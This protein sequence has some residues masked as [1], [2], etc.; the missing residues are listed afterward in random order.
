M[1]PDPFPH[2]PDHHYR[3]PKDPLVLCTKAKSQRHRRLFRWS[4]PDPTQMDVYR[5]H[6]R[7]V[8]HRGAVWRLPGH[9]CRFRER[10]SRRGTIYRHGCGS[11]WC[12]EEECRAASLSAVELQAED[13]GWGND[14]HAHYEQSYQQRVQLRGHFREQAL[15]GRHRQP[16]DQPHSVATA[17][18]GRTP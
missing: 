15:S 12:W 10:A 13:Q 14:G 1:L 18:M 2:R 7:S 8:R 6:H 5:V 11:Q 16:G 17:F 3:P 4:R 9:D